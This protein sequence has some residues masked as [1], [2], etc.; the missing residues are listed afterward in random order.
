[1][2]P[3]RPHKTSFSWGSVV[4]P[5]A[6]GRLLELDVVGFGAVEKE[7]VGVGCGGSFVS[8]SAIL[9]SIIC[10]SVEGTGFAT[11]GKLLV[12]FVII[13]LFVDVRG[14]CEV[15]KDAVLFWD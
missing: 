12:F 1:M 10:L 3:P 5:S 11:A 8:M 9:A 13:V 6:A 4:E 2:E 14:C 15:F 7:V